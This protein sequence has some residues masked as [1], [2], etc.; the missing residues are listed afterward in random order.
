M[1]TDSGPKVLEY[2]VRGGDPETQTLLPLL[3]K[4]TDLAKIMVASAD[5]HLDSVQIHVDNKF[6]ATVV[7]AAPGY[8]GSYTKNI[9]MQ[10]DNPPQDTIIFQAGTALDGGKVRTTGGR[11]IAGTGTA[12]TLEA[13]VAKAYEAMKA[14]HFEGMVR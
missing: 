5:G 14:I 4:D 9:S 11:V 12:G 7:A 3:S 1:V 8:P 10:L 13:A 2:N 6:S